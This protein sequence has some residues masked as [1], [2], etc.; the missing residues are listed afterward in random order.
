M[1]SPYSA[2]TDSFSCLYPSLSRSARFSEGGLPSADPTETDADANA[3]ANA[4]PV[5][6]SK[7]VS[8]FVV[9]DVYTTHPQPSTTGMARKRHYSQQAAPLAP[10]PRPVQHDDPSSH[11][12]HAHNAPDF[13]CNVAEHCH[14]S[15]PCDKPDC[16]E[17][18]I[19]FDHN[20]HDYL[21]CNNHLTW[22]QERSKCDDVYACEGDACNL[23]FDC[24]FPCPD[25]CDEADCHQPQHAQ[26]CNT[27]CATVACSDP[28]C[29][30][31]V[32]YCC[33]S[34]ICPHKAHTDCHQPCPPNCQI[35][36]TH[37]NAPIPPAC[38]QPCS[39]VD[40]PSLPA[41]LQ[42]C[43]LT[44]HT[45]CPASLPD[46]MSTSTISTPHTDLSDSLQTPTNLHFQ[47]LVEAAA[48]QAMLSAS[49]P[50]LWGD[51]PS[52]D[53]KYVHYIV[54]PRLMTDQLANASTASHLSANVGG[55]M[56]NRLSRSSTNRMS[57]IK[58]L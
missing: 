27:I 17:S 57:W 10:P 48:T 41:C 9:S 49:N 42:P 33:L 15:P 29:N 18:T 3:S 46:N 30:E 45:P 51:Y 58:P 12:A 43:N 23:D 21:P 55:S 32:L 28:Q 44:S 16:D 24:L 34:D 13:A 6:S 53:D 8:D 31:G 1:A 35:S 4:Q 22:C 25:I 36:H 47:S 7:N 11:T 20:A 56:A 52:F 26:G 50:G 19:C 5:T 54:P 2:W 37:C 14:F 38:L 40:A 39:A